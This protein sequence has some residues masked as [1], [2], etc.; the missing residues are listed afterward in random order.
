MSSLTRVYVPLS[1][2]D[3][4]QLADTGQLPGA[5]REVHGV[6]TKLERVQPGE[7]REG[8]EFLALQEAAGR[9]PGSR[10]VVGA[11]DLP[12]GQV[13][14]AVSGAASAMRVTGPVLRR[15][16]VSLHVGDEGE[17]VTDEDDVELSWY[18]ITELDEVRRLVGDG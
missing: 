9:A 12:S 11:A 2:D 13:A 17:V 18:D 16:V 6:T 3:L 14:P 15:Y 8:W 4:D 5:D 10:I 7:D 1:A